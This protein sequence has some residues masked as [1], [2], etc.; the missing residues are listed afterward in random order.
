MR[1]RIA[2]SPA[3]H[4]LSAVHV[5]EQVHVL[6]DPGVDSGSLCGLIAKMSGSIKGA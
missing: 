1:M 4:W 3:L 6:E 5:S 2:Y